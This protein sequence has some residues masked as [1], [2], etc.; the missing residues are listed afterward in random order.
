MSVPIIA[1]RTLVA[2]ATAWALGSARPA[3]AEPGRYSH[4]TGVWTGSLMLDGAGR[5]FVLRDSQRPITILKLWAGWCPECA[6]EMPQLAAMAFA[7]NQSVEVILVSHPQYWVADQAMARRRS[8]PFR[9]ATFAPSNSP[10]IVEQALLGRDG[11]YSVPKSLAFRER[12]QSIVLKRENATDWASAA[13]LSQIR[14]L[15]I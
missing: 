14:A 5:S 9:L 8:L 12:D 1:R 6:A 2:A 3:A 10:P 13:M 4:E 15:T 7:L 11:T